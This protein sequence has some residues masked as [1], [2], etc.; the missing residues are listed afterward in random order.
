MLC[1][2]IKRF[3][4]LLCRLCFIDQHLCFL[5]FSV[6]I[7]LK[8]IFF[9]HLFICFFILIFESCLQFALYVQVDIMMLTVESIPKISGPSRP[10]KPGEAFLQRVLV[11]TLLKVVFL[12]ILLT[13]VS[14]LFLALQTRVSLLFLGFQTRVSLLFLGLQN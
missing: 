4:L 2:I 14:L 11:K 6:Q 9:P 13:Q 1:L 12:H 3:R 10:L 8:I 7:W 5:G